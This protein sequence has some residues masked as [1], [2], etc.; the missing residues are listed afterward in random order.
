MHKILKTMHSACTTWYVFHEPSK[1]SGKDL[2]IC[3]YDIS[4]N[5]EHTHVT[6]LSG[7]LVSMALKLKET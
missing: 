5:S 6:V 4:Y 1:T 3:K 7:R 2:Y